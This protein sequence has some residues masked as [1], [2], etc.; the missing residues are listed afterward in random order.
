MK[1][2]LIA[3][4]LLL[5]VLISFFLCEFYNKKSL[6][7]TYLKHPCEV[8]VFNKI[9]TKQ[10]YVTLEFKNAGVLQNSES[11]HGI[12]A[13]ISKLLFRKINGLTVAETSEKL[14]QLGITNLSVNGL[15]DNFVISFSVVKDQFKQAVKFLISGLGEKFTENDLNYAKEFFPFQINPENS[16]PDEILLDK[17]YQNLYPSHVYGKNVTGSSDALTKV[18]LEDINNFIKSNFALNNL[19]IYYVG[20]YSIEELRRF[21]DEISRFLSRKSIP[22]KIDTLKNIKV[23]CTYEKIRNSNIR[24]ICGISTGVRLDN[25]SKHEKAAL[26]IIADTLFNKDNG[27][28]LNTDIPMNF[29]YSIGDRKLSTVLVFTAFIQKRN[30]D[31]YL[32]MQDN[33][34]SNLSLSKLKN[35]ELSKK[36]FI[37]NQKLYS[38]RSLKNTLILL[39]LPF[40]DCNDKYYQKIL[41]K[42]QQKEIRSTVSISEE[43]NSL[44]Q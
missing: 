8:I 24:D 21:I 1:K 35:L 44:N 23:N 4:S 15:S 34:L 25:L 26:Y 29:S 14:Q 38:L 11:Q 2:V 9:D 39:G 16:Q 27:L 5:I 20:A 42:I 36:S 19:R 3:S 18:T 7:L 10:N 12:S 28:F 43:E 33:F 17:L 30:L 6:P 31:K 32:K 13:L 37:E 40:K 41:R 22:S